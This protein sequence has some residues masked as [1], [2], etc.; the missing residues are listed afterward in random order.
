MIIKNQ[1]YFFNLLNDSIILKY[2]NTLY[3]FTIITKKK[4][5][6]SMNKFN[7]TAFFIFGIPLLGYTFDNYSLLISYDFFSTLI[8]KNLPFLTYI[9]ELNTRQI[10]WNTFNYTEQFKKI[11]WTLLKNFNYFNGAI[12]FTFNS[13]LKFYNNNEYIAILKLK[14]NFKSS[15]TLNSLDYYFFLGR[16]YNKFIKP[17]KKK[18]FLNL[19]NYLIN[20]NS[21]KIFFKFKKFN[22]FE[23]ISHWQ[24]FFY[25]LDDI[26]TKLD[27]IFILNEFSK[28]YTNSFFTI[29]PLFIGS[30]I[31]KDNYITKNEILEK[32][33][34]NFFYFNTITNSFLFPYYFETK[35]ISEE[36]LDLFNF[37]ILNSNFNLNLWNS[38][39][40]QYNIYTTFSFFKKCLNFHLITLTKNEKNFFKT[41]L[42]PQYNLFFFKTYNDCKQALRIDIRNLI[43]S[44]QRF[45]KYVFENNFN[46]ICTIEKP[47]SLREDQP[48]FGLKKKQK[49]LIPLFQKELFS[50]LHSKSKLFYFFQ[51][52]KKINKL[53]ILFNKINTYKI[54]KKLNNSTKLNFYC[55]NEK[56]LLNKKL[57][58][59]PNKTIL[60]SNI[61]NTIKIEQTEFLK[62]KVSGY[63]YPDILREN[64]N[65]KLIFYNPNQ[66]QS[67]SI[68]VSK[69]IGLKYSIYLHIKQ[70]LNLQHTFFNNYLK[71][72]NLILFETKEHFH[73]KSMQQ[74]F[75]FSS[76]QPNFFIKLTK[77]EFEN[78][79]KKLDEEL[80]K[81]KQNLDINGIYKSENNNN[82]INFENYNQ[83]SLDLQSKQIQHF[84][85][86][87]LSLNLPLK[88]NENSKMIS[89]DKKS[90][91]IDLKRKRFDEKLISFNSKK[92]YFQPYVEEIFETKTPFL[93]LNNLLENQKDFYNK[94]YYKNELKK[95]LNNQTKLVNPLVLL[96]YSLEKFNT[97][98]STNFI[99]KKILVNFE[100]NTLIKLPLI[101][102]EEKNFTRVNN[103]FAQFKSLKKDIHLYESILKK[104]ISYL[105]QIFFL[106]II[107]TKLNN[108][109]KV[110][111]D[112]INLALESFLSELKV[113]SLIDLKEA[114]YKGIIESKKIKFKNLAGGN[115]F[116]NKFSKTILL[117]KNS[118]KRF[119][120]VIISSPTKLPL[121]KLLKTKKFH[122]SSKFFVIILSFLYLLKKLKIAKKKSIIQNQITKQ[123]ISK[124]FIIVGPSGSGK[125]ILVKALAGEANVPII[126]DSGFAYIKSSATDDMKN[127]AQLKQVFRLA[128]KKAPCILFIDEIDK[129]GQNRKDVSTYFNTKQLINQ[130]LIISIKNLKKKPN[131]YWQLVN[132]VL[133]NAFVN[134]NES[135][136]NIFQSDLSNL[137]K[138][139]ALS[140]LTQFLCE[141]DGIKNRNDI[142]IIG[143]TNKL[144]S[145]DPAL[146]RPGRLNQVI[147]VNFPNKSKRLELLKK[148]SQIEKNSSINWK[149]FI[150]QTNGFTSADI[151]SAM[152]ISA[153]KAIYKKLTSSL[154]FQKK[155]NLVQTIIHKIL[156]QPKFLHD[157]ETIEYGIEI[158][159]I[160]TNDF[161]YNNYKNGYYLNLLLF[162][163][164]H[165]DKNSIFSFFINQFFTITQNN[166]FFIFPLYKKNH[167]NLF[168]TKSNFF[169]NNLKNSYYLFL[170]LSKLKFQKNNLNELQQNARKKFYQ[171]SK[172][173]LRTLY[174]LKNKIKKGINLKEKK[175]KFKLKQ[176]LNIKKFYY[177][178]NRILKLHLFGCQL[179]TNA[180]CSIKNL[181]KFSFQFK[182]TVFSHQHL[183]KY[184]LLY[185]SNNYLFTNY[186]NLCKIPNFVFKNS[187]DLNR[188]LYYISGKTIIFSLLN[189]TNFNLKRLSFWKIL[190][191]ISEKTNKS[192]K[193]FQELFTHCTTKKHFEN[194][195]LFLI[196]GKATEICII[197]NY[198]FNNWSN[199]ENYDLQKIYWLI[200]I[201]IEKNLFYNSIKISNLKQMYLKQI[202]KQINLNK[203]NTNLL[204]KKDSFHKNEFSLHLF[205]KKFN[206]LIILFNQHIKNFNNFK[207]IESWHKMPYWWEY[208]IKNQILLKKVLNNFYGN[209]YN[210]FILVPRKKIKNKILSKF[211]YY[212]FYYYNLINTKL[213]IKN[214]SNKKK[215]NY[216]D[217]YLIHWNQLQ[218]I[219]SNYIVVNL[220]FTSFNKVFKIIEKNKELLDCFAYY[221][222][223]NEVLYDFEIT[224]FITNY[225]INNNFHK[226][227]K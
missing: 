30:N 199:L 59:I 145:L 56:I 105:T 35:T 129:I 41:S 167:I 86:K 125:T 138:K 200:I 208:K 77:K 74:Q 4:I 186:F 139:K 189:E 222:L 114:E 67:K 65:K 101:Y 108:L 75:F 148:S 180:T 57:V 155:K 80:V 16:H 223:C 193:F 95:N 174:L 181:I 22:N 203:P 31:Q 110:Y 33:I 98:L 42:H 144:E 170:Y 17:L 99:F 69:I 198:L 202:Q 46:Q 182:Q 78:G 118:K 37:S 91:I 163:Q 82:T 102:K 9:T 215:L 196:S 195:L 135:N 25:E 187:F 72:I 205:K 128:K 64:L 71:L 211:Y 121:F 83:T 76:L 137:K 161:Q 5:K 92:F 166:S 183:V 157:F 73:F 217:H 13:E 100:S 127:I 192:K 111:Q 112:A 103:N 146:I 160:R 6:K 216:S 62:R 119:N 141:I 147:Y 130:N 29:K 184:T 159:N 23:T 14:K 168:Y 140:M 219:E 132:P 109:R 54:I 1:K 124:G 131:I 40:F 28:F 61:Q 143:T 18:N 63:Q 36:Q 70:S 177:Y 120:Q 220:L 206:F 45:K 224:N 79:L 188:I 158:I 185:S 32:N 66:I 115:F 49:S 134:K 153:L 113:E 90:T 97:I 26:P 39:L 226:K 60:L 151:A 27:N 122:Y 68:L 85:A 175:L 12:F 172:H 43:L 2:F 194:Y 51:K 84:I 21:Q 154:V 38:R 165:F 89:F 88:F 55:K 152:Q 47:I 87:F 15:K 213:L 179:L 209:W 93:Y 20:Q 11:N 136:Q 150:D 117:L 104:K 176:I 126:I 48:Y 204:S 106:L 96:N 94:F 201:M 221:F 225:F 207:K 19:F 212:D 142:I 227:L 8:K 218:S 116:L 164:T 123:F 190:Q 44:H 149:I 107:A 50:C 169:C 81:E 10:T 191:V 162:G 178:I 214:C 210:F 3:L 52:K 53:L 197:Q 58:F 171:N 7:S 173:Y 24:S 133:A 34:K 156:N